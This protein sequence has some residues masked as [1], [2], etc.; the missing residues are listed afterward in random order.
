MKS[1]LLVFSTFA[2]AME[3]I[4]ADIVYN[5]DYEPPTY[6]NGQQVGGGTTETITD[7]INGFSSQA[8]LIHDGGGL[9]YLAPSTFTSGMHLVTWDMSIPTVQGSS[10]ILNVQLIAE[11]GPTLFSTTAAGDASTLRVEYGSGFP[12][13]P[14]VTI[15]EGQSY[16]FQVFMDLDADYYSFWLDAALLEDT[17]SIPS[18]ASLWLVGFGQNQSLGLQAGIDNFRWEVV[19]EPTSALLILLGGFGI[20]LARHRKQAGE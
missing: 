8:L 7:S 12:M 3:S 11:G 13:R 6:T 2:L 20:Y 17:V 5:I 15:N 10:S 4:Y 16:F 19:P 9:N 18:E 14:S 1:I